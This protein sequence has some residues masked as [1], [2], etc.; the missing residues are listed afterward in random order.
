[1]S[2]RLSVIEWVIAVAIAVPLALL[3]IIG[4]ESDG[5]VSYVCLGVFLISIVGL[6]VYGLYLTSKLWDDCD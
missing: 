3:Y 4:H 5:W 6:I 1:M 2:I